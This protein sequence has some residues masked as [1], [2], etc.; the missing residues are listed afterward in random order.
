M[1]NS[2]K[3]IRPFVLTKDPLVQRIL[4]RFAKRSENG[5]KKYGRTMVD[6][7]KSIDEWIDDAQEESWDKIVYLEK[8]KIELQKKEG[9]KHGKKEK[10]K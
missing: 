1:S 2:K 3:I 6:A 9:V 7:T 5:I 8:I 4:E 10:E